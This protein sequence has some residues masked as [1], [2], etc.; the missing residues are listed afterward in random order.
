MY[1]LT[2]KWLL[3]KKYRMPMVQLTDYIKLNMKEGPSM[4]AS[5]PL[6]RGNKI[7][8]GSRERDE[9]EWGWG[10]G[11]GKG[12]II[13]LCGDRR[14]TQRARRMNGNLQQCGVVAG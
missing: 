3:A 8:M 5:F 13:R 10:G 14:E 2:D 4:D 11:R 9:C 12:C 6:R 1:V 7:I